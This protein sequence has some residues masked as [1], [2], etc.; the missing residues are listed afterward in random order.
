M[1]TSS[2]LDLSG[3]WKFCLDAD[4]AGIGEK[5][6]GR[7]FGDTIV[8]PGTTAEAHKGIHGDRKETGYLT[9]PY[10]FEGHAW[11]SRT[12]EIPEE[13]MGDLAQLVI[14]RTRISYVW[15][16][17]NFVGTQ[18]SFATAHKYDLTEYLSRKVHKLTVMVSTVDNKTPGGQMTSPDTQTNWNGMLGQIAIIF[19]PV[20]RVSDLCV[21]ASAELRSVEVKFNAQC[22]KSA[23]KGYREARETSG[24]YS[25]QAVITCT[26]L[27][28]T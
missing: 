26:A 22:C 14:E 7:E 28:H 9:E 2:I 8:L 24:M 5:Y 6:Y 12:L 10:H 1:A 3:V 18:D 25:V 19:E 23:I 15:L 11:Y 4:K 17:E 13:H 27:K 21:L 16:D 20:V